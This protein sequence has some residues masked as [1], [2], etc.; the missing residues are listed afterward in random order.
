MFSLTT[1]FN[2]LLELENFI[3]EKNKEEQQIKIKKEKKEG[4][5]RGANVK[6]LHQRAKLYHL[7]NPE[8]PYKQCLKLA[9][10]K[11]N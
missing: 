6:E 9:N 4:D 5:R 1:N 10:I 8:T 7:E 11:K 2:T 3:K